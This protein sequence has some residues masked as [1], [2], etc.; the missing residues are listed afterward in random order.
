MKGII[1]SRLTSGWLDAGR[2]QESPQ[3][4]KTADGN[5]WVL[6]ANSK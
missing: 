6:L 4:F 2:I 5:D 3:S 1:S